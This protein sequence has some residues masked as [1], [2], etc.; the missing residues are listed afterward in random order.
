MPLRRRG[1]NVAGSLFSDLYED[2]LNK[3]VL[4][5]EFGLLLSFGSTFSLGKY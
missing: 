2:D 4:L 5:E 1:F 3:P